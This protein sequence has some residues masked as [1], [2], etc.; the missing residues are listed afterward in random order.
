MIYASLGTSAAW[1][2]HVLFECIVKGGL[3]ISQQVFVLLVVI[4]AGLI[5]I[6]VFSTA[7]PHF[8]RVFNTRT[9]PNWNKFSG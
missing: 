3:I 4:L 7:L 9:F 6:L 1:H 8:L 2:T 5:L